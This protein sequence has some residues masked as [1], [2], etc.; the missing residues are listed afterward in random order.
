MSKLNLNNVTSGFAATTLINS[1][2]TAITN[3]VENTLSR[4]GTGPNQMN[5]PLDM[6]GN[7]ILNQANPITVN[8][9]NW[10]GP[11]VTL[12]IYSVG[13]VIQIN[14]SS[15][16][17]IVTHTAGVFA[18]DLSAGKWQIVASSAA[19]PS[20]SG[21]AGKL[22]T[23]DGNNPS[24]AS[25][26][27]LAL[28]IG[29]GTVTGATTF[30]SNLSV[31]GNETIGGTLGVTGAITPSQTNGIVGTTTNNNANAGSVGE[32]VSSLITGASAVP[33]VTQTSKNVTSIPLTAGDWQLGGTVL[34][35]YSATTSITH[36][37]GSI[38]QT[39]NTLDA[40]IRFSLPMAAY[41]P[42]G[43]LTPMGF[44]IQ[45]TRISLSGNTT[46]YLVAYGNFTVSTLSAYGNIWARRVR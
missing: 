44:A 43:S 41:V 15:Y 8:G 24:W 45:S 2:N 3:A 19:L 33:L 9:F 7:M 36:I 14:N 29:G 27:T 39:T 20:Q 30:S 31:T 37:Q 46:I 32:Y 38:S 13:D 4:D 42:G 23:T 12:S 16:I 28:P 17:C 11:W 10:K 18:T 40:D 25:V 34:F 35:I 26:D 21:N 5:A 1:N 6:N 22:I